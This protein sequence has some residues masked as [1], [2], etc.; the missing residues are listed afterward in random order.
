M[1]NQRFV[2]DLT[3]WANDVNVSMDALARQSIQSLVENVKYDTPFET[4]NLLGQWQPSINST[5]PIGT[6]SAR[7]I[8]KCN[9][10]GN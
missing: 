3:E 1:P 8:R 4:G 7:R 5:P 2:A 6:A 9:F 10:A